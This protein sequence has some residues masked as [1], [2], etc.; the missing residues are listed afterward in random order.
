[1]CLSYA[2]VCSQVFSAFE[3][4]ERDIL[5][6]LDVDRSDDALTRHKPHER[7]NCTA[8]RAN[9]T[10]TSAIHTHKI[11]TCSHAHMHTC[12]HAH[13]QA[14]TRMQS[15]LRGL[16]AKNAAQKV[17]YKEEKRTVHTHIHTYTHTHIQ[18][19]TRTHAHTHTYIHT[20]A[21]NRLNIFVSACIG[22]C[23]YIEDA[24]MRFRTFLFE[25]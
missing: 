7:P 1:M 22:F 5:I 15:H 24:R 9:I 18:T 16:F 13:A 11:I 20:Y 21:H 14:V 2:N 4:D 23:V 3:V 19:H 12:S 25:I 10:H 8:T 6:L 17:R